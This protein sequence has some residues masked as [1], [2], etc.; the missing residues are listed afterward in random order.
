MTPI[1]AHQLAGLTIPQLLAMSLERPP[2]E[3]GPLATL[4]EYMATVARD[5]AIAKAWRNI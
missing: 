3:P 5:E 2:G 4:D 1:L